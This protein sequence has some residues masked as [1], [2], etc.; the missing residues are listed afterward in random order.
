M[1]RSFGLTLISAAL[2][3]QLFMIHERI[4][5]EWMQEK[6]YPRVDLPVA[7]NSTRIYCLGK[8]TPQL[9]LSRRGMW[10]ADGRD[11]MTDAQAQEF[12]R[13]SVK[14]SN[15]QGYAPVIRM[16][17]GA[18]EKASKFIK[19]AICAEEAGMSMIYVAAYRR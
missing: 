1:I 5:A 2:L 17:I 18:R 10:I 11:P 6:S 13:E 12:I 15:S 9:S 7:S 8:H 16:R 4:W 19:M 3:V 14:E